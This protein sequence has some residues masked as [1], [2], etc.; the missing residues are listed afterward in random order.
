MPR[1]I[2]P[3]AILNNI[4]KCWHQASRVSNSVKL[5]EGNADSRLVR[6][7]FSKYIFSESVCHCTDISVARRSGLEGTDE[8][9]A[10]D[11]SC[12][13]CGDR[14]KFWACCIQ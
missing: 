3:V 6:N 2:L 13:V 14:M 12:L 9:N 4:G 8:M 1:N 11:L 5:L 10:H 7:D